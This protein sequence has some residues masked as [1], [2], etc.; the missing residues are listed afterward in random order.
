MDDAGLKKRL[1][2]VLCSQAVG[3]EN[4]KSA[5]TLAQL[6]G[7]KQSRENVELRGLIRDL[8][9]LGYPVCAATGARCRGFFIATERQ[10]LVRYRD[11]LSN[12]IAEIAK[13]RDAVDRAI[14]A[15]DEMRAA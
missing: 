11:S 9:F 4:A 12:R 2:S 3:P 1:L 8:L 13:R 6:V 14:A 10:Q 7:I 5:D 15:W